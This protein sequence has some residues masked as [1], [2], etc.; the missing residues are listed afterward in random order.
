MLSLYSLSGNSLP[1]ND[2]FCTG[3][4]VELSGHIQA[5]GFIE[6]IHR[7]HLTF[8]VFVFNERKIAFVNF[9]P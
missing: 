1:A 4:V 6:L 8:G 9:Y 7:A 3:F 5:F 2:K